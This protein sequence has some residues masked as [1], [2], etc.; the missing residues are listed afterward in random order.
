M[1]TQG[2][3]TILVALARVQTGLTALS[4]AWLRSESDRLSQLP[5]ERVI[6]SSLSV[7]HTSLTTISKTLETIMAT[8]AD[9][10]TAETEEAGAIAD[11]VAE[12]AKLE[13]DLNTAQTSGADPAAMQ[14]IVDQIHANTAKLK[15]A[16]PPATPATPPEEPPP[17]AA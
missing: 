5:G 16:L 4:E 11:V 14:A 2:E 8:L 1:P 12:I 3:R 13:S 7:I 17:A 10:Q 6:M 15:A 9:I